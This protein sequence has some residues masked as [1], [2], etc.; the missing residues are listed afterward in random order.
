M[1]QLD[2]QREYAALLANLR[3]YDRLAGTGEAAERRECPRFHV[4]TDDL[5]IN[6]V[7]EFAVLDMSATGIAISSTYPLHSGDRVDVGLGSDVEAQAE[8]VG[9]RLVDSPT[10]YYPAEFRI[11]CRFTDRQRGMEVLVRAKH[12]ERQGPAGRRSSHA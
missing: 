4:Q 11:N 1:E 2:V 5:W 7:P 12:G 8:V 9:C 10:L 6:E 3:G